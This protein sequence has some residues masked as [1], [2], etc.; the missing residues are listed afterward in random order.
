[1]NAGEALAVAKSAFSAVDEK[2]AAVAVMQIKLAVKL[3]PT[4]TPLLLEAVALPNR[5]TSRII[6][7]VA[8][9]ATVLFVEMGQ[10]VLRNESNQ[11]FFIKANLVHVSV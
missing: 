5:R 1:M 3:E 7:H 11:I 2:T 8:A 9:E 4:Y 6:V 10:F